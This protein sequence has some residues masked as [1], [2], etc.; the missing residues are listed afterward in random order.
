MDL[1]RKK[2]FKCLAA[3]TG[4]KALEMVTEYK[5]SAVLL[6]LGL[7][8]MDGMVVLDELK[9]NLA[10]RHIPVHIISG[11]DK[12]IAALTKGALGFLN[13]P[14]SSEDVLH[15]LDG[16]EKLLHSTVKQLLVIE[17]DESMRRLIA[18]SLKIKGVEISV[19]APV[20]FARPSVDVLFNSAADVYGDTLVGV[21]LTGAN[22]D[23][24]EGLK[25]I[26]ERGGLTLVQDPA[27]A[28]AD[29]MPRAAM[30]AVDVDHV[31][32]LEE[33]GPFLRR[34]CASPVSV[35]PSGKSIQGKLGG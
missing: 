10:T 29:A 13:K 6:D 35:Q 18:H 22:N 8:D 11:R 17:D 23:G 2:G 31:L 7:P 26:K 14:V 34:L 1:C 5:P 30:K 19:D 3:G 33:I 15:A 25:R 28:H 27:T 21:V 24:A 9:H 16:I 12:N 32:H 20:N 4:G